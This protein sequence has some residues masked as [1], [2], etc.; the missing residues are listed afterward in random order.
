MYRVWL[1]PV[2]SVEEAQQVSHVLGILGIE[3]PRVVVE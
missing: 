2:S 3:T 1:G